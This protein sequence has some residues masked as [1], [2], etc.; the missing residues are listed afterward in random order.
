[1]LGLPSLLE[2]YSRQILW[3]RESPRH[4]ICVKILLLGESCEI[5]HEYWHHYLSIWCPSRATT[6]N[7]SCGYINMIVRLKTR[8][9]SLF[10]PDGAI[11][12]NMVLLWPFGIGR[13]ILSYIT[14]IAFSEVACSFSL[15][16]RSSRRLAVFDLSVGGARR[17]MP[18]VGVALWQTARGTQTLYG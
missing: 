14:K 5:F 7:F 1:M 9:V 12:L 11:W 3:P 16:F 4:E 18:H 2:K 17:S 6:H 8:I 13:S 15:D 10:W